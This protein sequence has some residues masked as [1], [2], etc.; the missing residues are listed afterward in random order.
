MDKTSEFAP[1]SESIPEASAIVETFI[2]AGFHFFFAL[3]FLVF[4]GSECKMICVH[5]FHVCSV[6]PVN[7]RGS[8]SRVRFPAC[9]RDVK[10]TNYGDFFVVSCQIYLQGTDLANKTLNGVMFLYQI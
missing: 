6:R 2:A 1:T 3:D 10:I 7:V 5:V 8:V 9:I 4:A